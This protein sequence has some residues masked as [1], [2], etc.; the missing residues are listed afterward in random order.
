M[1]QDLDRGEGEDAA[2]DVL[3]IVTCSEH[4]TDFQN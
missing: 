4:R 1:K 3:A 2:L